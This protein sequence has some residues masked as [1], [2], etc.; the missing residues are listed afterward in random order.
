MFLRD[1]TVR[2]LLVLILTLGV[3]PI[4]T[5]QIALRVCEAD[6]VTPFDGSDIMVGTNLTLIVS[7]DANDYWSGGL[8]VAGQDRALAT[9]SARDSDPNT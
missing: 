3:V 2:K 4:A 8:F 6:G 1:V 9:L 5:A 7:S